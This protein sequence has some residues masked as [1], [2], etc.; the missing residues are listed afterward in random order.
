MECP[1]LIIC[2][3][4]LW[5]HKGIEMLQ[6]LLPNYTM[7]FDNRRSG[8]HGRLIVYIHDDFAYKN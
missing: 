7:L 1:I 2:F 4:D 5:A 3:Q 6:F 8:T